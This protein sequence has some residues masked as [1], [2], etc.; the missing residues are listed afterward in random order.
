ME[1]YKI[2]MLTVLMV[3]EITAMVILTIG[4]FKACKEAKERKDDGN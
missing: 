3:L 1:P 2:V 4:W